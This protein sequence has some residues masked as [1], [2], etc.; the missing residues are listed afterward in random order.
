MLKIRRRGAVE[1]YS[2]TPYMVAALQCGTWTTYAIVTPCKIQPLVTNS[3]GLVLELCYIVWFIFYAGASTRRVLLQTSGYALVF[4]VLAGFGVVAAPHLPI[5]PFPSQTPPLSKQTTVLGFVCAG[6]NVLMYASPLAIMRTVI[7]TKSVEYMP[8]PLTL[9]VGLC[10][11]F[12]LIFAIGSSPVDPFIFVPNAAGLLLCVMQVA[13]Y[14]AYCGRTTAKV[15]S[16]DAHDESPA[17]V[18]ISPIAAD[19]AQ[20]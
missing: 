20:R 19:T 8:L 1:E 9:A 10:S 15:L 11:T 17:R 5:T 13:L 14:A 16:G 7:R 3:V 2:A 18:L 12:W 4:I 6:L